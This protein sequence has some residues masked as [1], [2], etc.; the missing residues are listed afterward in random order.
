MPF[1]FLFLLL[2]NTHRSSLKM[3]VGFYMLLTIF[4]ILALRYDVGWDYMSYS[5]AFKYGYDNFEYLSSLI[6]D[7]SRFLGSVNYVFLIYAFL[8]I[9]PLLLVFY[10]ERKLSFI[11]CYISLPFFFIES[12]S[13]IRQ[14]VAL[15]FCILGY[16][17]Y[18]RRDI[19]AFLVLMVAV[20][21]HSSAIVFLLMIIVLWFGN[22][23][24]K[25][26]ILTSLVILAV[27]FDSIFSLFIPFF[28]TLSFYNSGSSY[29]LLSVL[30]VFLLFIIS[31]NKSDNLEHYYL[32][33]V[34]II[35]NI[36][37]LNFDSA[38]AR[39][40]W[41][42]YIPFCFLTWSRFFFKLK[43][44]HWFFYL[45]MLFLYSYSLMLKS[46]LENGSYLPYQTIL[47]V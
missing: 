6:F 39:L 43:V 31:L 12:F 14:E 8:T 46:S 35:L 27:Y 10:L 36:I 21:F 25:L 29:G 40:C 22:R 26:C 44:G 38:L 37:L 17:L 24:V 18:L 32:I 16:L 41:Y 42:F 1:M 23:L 4:L 19:K 7:I 2:Y 13:V 33:L 11:V 15:S 20:G 45:V 28:P 5:K 30:S 3:L 9:L 47:G 34:G